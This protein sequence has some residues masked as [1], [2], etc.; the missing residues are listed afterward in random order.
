M[1]KNTPTGLIF[2][3]LAGV[4][5]AVLIVAF[6]LNPGAESVQAPDS[7]FDNAFSASDVPEGSTLFEVQPLESEAR[8]ILDEL[9]RGNPKTVIGSTDEVGGQLVVDFDNLPL[10]AFSDFVILAETLRTDSSFRDTAVRERILFADEYPLIIFK[11]D[12]LIDMPESI[13]V[14]NTAEFEVEGKLIVKGLTKQQSFEVIATAVSPTQIDLF[15]T[16]VIQRADY[17]LTIPQVQGVANVDE[18]I[19][20]ELDLVLTAVEE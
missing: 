19:L 5:T 6:I 11:P 9:L 8:F 4:G 18:A 2:I 13:A 3:L 7:N 10:V 12:S 17:D 1:K 15:A 16:T 14:G 20:L